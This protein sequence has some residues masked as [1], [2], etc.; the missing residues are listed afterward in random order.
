MC[1]LCADFCSDRF[2]V[3]PITQDMRFSMHGFLRWVTVLFPPLPQIDQSDK[4]SILDSHKALKRMCISKGFIF[5]WEVDKQTRWLV[6]ANTLNYWD[7]HLAQDIGKTTKQDEI[8][9]WSW[10]CLGELKGERERRKF[11]F[12]EVY[13]RTKNEISWA[14]QRFALRQLQGDCSELQKTSD[15]CVDF[16]SND[17]LFTPVR[18]ISLGKK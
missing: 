6:T 17:K 18:E 9:F 3:T 7:V 1:H 14:M 8:I 11:R 15:K 13:L 5:F 16:K 10:I 12:L 4:N 2:K